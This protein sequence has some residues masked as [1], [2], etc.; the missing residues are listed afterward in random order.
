MSNHTVFISNLGGGKDYSS[1]AKFG[2]MRPITSGNFPIFK[3]DRLMEEVITAI[4]D[5]EPD[6]YLVLSGSG[7]VTALCLS[8]WLIIHKKARL[9]LFDKR[10]GDKGQYVPRTVTREEIILSIEH[11]KERKDAERLRS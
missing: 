3:T 5:S 6:D 10:Q 2:A 4:L 9:L 1:V 8:V 7:L 11:I